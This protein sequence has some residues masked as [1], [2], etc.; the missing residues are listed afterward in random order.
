MLTFQDEEISKGEKKIREWRVKLVRLRNKY[1]ES[2]NEWISDQF[3]DM[4]L[5]LDKMK[6]KVDELK[7]P[8]TERFETIKD[9]I[10]RIDKKIGREFREI[11]K[12]LL[13]NGGN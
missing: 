8:G 6:I 1:D 4:L 12:E 10:N 2:L 11:E 13:R 7:T 5:N 3:E 9:E